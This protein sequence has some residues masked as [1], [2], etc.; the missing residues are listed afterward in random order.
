MQAPQTVAATPARQLDPAELKAL[1]ERVDALA[2]VP[3]GPALAAALAAVLAAFDCDR[4]PGLALVRMMEARNRQVNHEQGELLAA[5]VQVL[6]DDV[7][8]GARMW[9]GQHWGAVDQVRASLRLTR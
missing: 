7:P 3:A 6:L 1:L 9:R 8:G 4:L 2:K 5:V